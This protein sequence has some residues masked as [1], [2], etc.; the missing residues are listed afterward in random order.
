MHQTPEEVSK[1]MIRTEIILHLN[2]VL[3]FQSNIET[4]QHQFS[5]RKYF[6]LCKLL[7]NQVNNSNSVIRMTKMKSNLS[8][9]VNIF[10]LQAS[11]LNVHT[12]MN[13][14]SVP[15]TRQRYN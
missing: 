13:Y 10:I 5:Y 2:Y 6:P 4:L 12:L 8:V 3:K 11:R 15:E 9:R 1:N 14:E 7:G